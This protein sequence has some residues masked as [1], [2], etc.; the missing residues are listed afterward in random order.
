MK[1][2]LKELKTGEEKKE[3]RINF[4]P[5]YKELEKMSTLFFL[6]KNKKCVEGVLENLTELL[7]FAILQRFYRGF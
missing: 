3:R 2:S 6:R 1:D 4:S 7:S 5:L